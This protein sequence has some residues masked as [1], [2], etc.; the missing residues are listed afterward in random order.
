VAAEPSPQCRP[1]PERRRLNPEPSQHPYPPMRLQM[2][3]Q[4]NQ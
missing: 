3:L 4:S 1:P 2:P